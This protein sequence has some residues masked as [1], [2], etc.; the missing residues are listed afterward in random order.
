[1]KKYSKAQGALEFLMTYGWAFLVILVMVGA[2]AYFGILNPSKFLP[3]RCNFGAEVM[4]KKGE[5]VIQNNNAETIKVNLINQFGSTVKVKSVT[6]SSDILTLDSANC[7]KVIFGSTDVTK[8]EFTWGEGKLET[9]RIGCTNG[10]DLPLGDKVKV[11]LNIQ[12][13]TATGSSDFSHAVSGDIYT[14][15]AEYAPPK[16]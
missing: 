9:L 16:K 11:G 3:D 14:S 12:W 6:T 4:C 1:M 13:Y 2:L 10:E 8:G 15:I 5:F 7:G